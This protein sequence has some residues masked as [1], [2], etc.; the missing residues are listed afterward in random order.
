MARKSYVVVPNAIITAPGAS[1]TKRL[2]VA[3]LAY[4]MPRRKRGQALHTTVKSYDQLCRISGIRSHTTLHSAIRQLERSGI[5]TVTRHYGKSVERRQMER[6]RS[7]YALDAAFL[8]HLQEQSGYTL[9]PR[10]LLACGL[11]NAHFAVALLLYKLAGSRGVARPSIRQL[12]K[13][14]GIAKSTVCLAIRQAGLLQLFVR[15]LRRY[16]G[17]L[18]GTAFRKSRYCATNSPFAGVQKPENSGKITI[19]AKK[20]GQIYFSV[21]GGPKNGEQVLLTG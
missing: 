6:R 19:L 16:V 11:S 9:V 4:S 3:L 18:G 13:M 12:A 20:S 5:L 15:I 21:R 8:R 10:Q 2:L 14:L 7:A 1:S 17:R